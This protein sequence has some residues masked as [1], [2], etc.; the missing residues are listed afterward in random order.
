MTIV[1]TVE[2]LAFS[3][4]IPGRTMDWVVLTLDMN[5]V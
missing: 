3:A 2:D 5:L 4:A 1:T